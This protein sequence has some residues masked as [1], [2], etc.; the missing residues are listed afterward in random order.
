MKN[1]FMTRPAQAKPKSEPSD[2]PN[3]QSESQPSNAQP[4]PPQVPSNVPNPPNTFLQKKNF[5]FSESNNTI[6]FSIESKPPSHNIFHR[7]QFKIK[8]VPANR[9]QLEFFDYAKKLQ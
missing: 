1:K 4:S 2:P 7:P 9:P 3:Q 6:A 8:S 5:Y